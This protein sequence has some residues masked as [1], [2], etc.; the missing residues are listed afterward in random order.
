MSCV[1]KEMRHRLNSIMAKICQKP[2]TAFCRLLSAAEK[3]HYCFHNI[4]LTFE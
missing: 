2:T 1:S 3:A 4:L